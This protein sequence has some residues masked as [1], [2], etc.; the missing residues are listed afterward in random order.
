VPVTQ[1]REYVIPD[2]VKKA[3]PVVCGHRI[4]LKNSERLLQNGKQEVMTE[5]LET[6]AVPAEMI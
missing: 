3:F 6:V 2:D 1:G 5:I 4:N